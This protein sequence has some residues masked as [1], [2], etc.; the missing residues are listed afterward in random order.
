MIRR[1]TLGHITELASRPPPEGTRLAKG[2]AKG[3]RW[4]PP[5]DAMARHVLTYPIDGHLRSSN[6]DS[7][8]TFQMNGTRHSLCVH[9]HRRDRHLYANILQDLFVKE[10]TL[11]PEAVEAVELD[12]SPA[13]NNVRAVLKS[14][15]GK[16]DMV[17]TGT[18]TTDGV[19][20]YVH[21]RKR[22]SEEELRNIELEKERRKAIKYVIDGDQEQEQE[23][24]LE[25]EQ[26]QKM[27]TASE[28]QTS[29]LGLVGM[30]KLVGTF[31]LTAGRYYSES[32]VNRR[33]KEEKEVRKKCGLDEVDVAESLG[34]TSGA[35][36]IRTHAATIRQFGDLWSYAMRRKMRIM[37]LRNAAGKKRVL[38]YHWSQVRRKCGAPKGR[39]VVGCAKV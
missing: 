18:V 15:I 2:V 38:T 8:P 35:E 12:T 34:A 24:E 19:T 29:S 25:Q 23:L 30:F 21:F 20:A 1:H 6:E 31:K 37:A 27:R 10:G 26:E 3:L 32:G 4:L 16:K 11:A 5:H 22:K 28:Q 36:K 39:D 17:F 14:N 9:I 7:Q 13:A 33:T